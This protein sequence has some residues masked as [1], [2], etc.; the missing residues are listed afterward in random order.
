MERKNDKIIIKESKNGKSK[1]M[2]GDM[3]I[4][5]F[6]SEYEIKYCA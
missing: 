6:V 2:L 3:D 1:I 4:S 5:G